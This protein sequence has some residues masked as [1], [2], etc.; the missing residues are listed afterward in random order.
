MPM[1]GPEY[2]RNGH[3]ANTI[4]MNGRQ[5]F[6]FATQVVSDSIQDVVRKA[7]LTMDDISLIVPHQANIR[8]IETAA[9]RLKVSKEIFHVNVEEVGNTSAA[10]IPIAL[11]DAVKKGRLKP[12]DN[13][14][15]VGFGGGLTWAS[16]VIKWNVTPPEIPLSEKE[17]KRAR[18]IWARTRSK[19]RKIRRRVVDRVSKSPTPQARLKDAPK[20]NGEVKT[21]K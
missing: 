20:L 2:L 4:Y 21:K 3:K 9:K 6:R 5:V 19:M 13:I 12:D 15:F 8:I 16:S 7:D 11:C 1:L 18:Y 10:S 17:W 14:V